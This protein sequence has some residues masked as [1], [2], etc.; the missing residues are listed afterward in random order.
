[1]IKTLN[2]EFKMKTIITII[3]MFA[4]LTAYSQTVVVDSSAEL[5]IQSGSD[6]CATSTGNITGH[7]TGG[8]T[9]CNGI[10]PVELSNFSCTILNEVRVKLVWRTMTELN[11]SG[12]EIYRS[13]KNTN[14]NWVKAGFVRG[15]GT[16]N[17]TTEYTYTDA[18][19][20]EGKYYYRLKQIDNNGNYRIYDMSGYAVIKPPSKYMLAQ[21]YP[22]PFNPV[23]KINYQIPKDSRVTLKIYDATGREVAVILNN[24]SRAADYYTVEFNASSLASG[25]YFYKLQADSYSQVLKM[26]VLK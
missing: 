11:N 15:T 26:V 13:A 5:N 3:I 1:M 16:T 9:Q 4:A 21:N 10:L 25:V 6:M 19:L 24:V 20:T 23:T 12:F 14:T 2:T 17:N 8:G 22:N 18:N 7:V